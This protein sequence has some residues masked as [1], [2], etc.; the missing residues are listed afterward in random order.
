MNILFQSNT[1]QLLLYLYIFVV[2][3]K[4]YLTQL[5]KLFKPKIND[6]NQICKN[7]LMNVRVPNNQESIRYNYYMQIDKFIS[8]NYCKSNKYECEEYFCMN[9]NKYIIPEFGQSINLVID[10]I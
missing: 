10:D 8:D 7:K 1:L 2:M 6:T 3:M 9:N 5:S 4:F